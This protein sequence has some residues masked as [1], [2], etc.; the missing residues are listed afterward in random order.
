MRL[1][2]FFCFV[3][4]VDMSKFQ[5]VL[6]KEMKVDVSEEQQKQISSKE[7]IK[8]ACRKRKVIAFDIIFDD[9]VIGFAMLRKY[10][11][12]G[13]FLW[14]YAID[15]NYQNQGYGS[16][17]LK[18]LFSFMKNEYKAKEMTTTYIWG[19][20]HAKHVYEKAG[21]IE[22]DVIDEPDCHEVNMIIK[23]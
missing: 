15:K 4:N 18:E 14:D 13:Y 19:N 9:K 11:R 1:Y 17:A 10:S 20:E 12:H 5:F 21:F 16:E 2:C 22:T 8:T 6:S 3:D 7:N 23:L